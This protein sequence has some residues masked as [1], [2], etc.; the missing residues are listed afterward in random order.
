MTTQ[1][2]P[3]VPSPGA[4]PDLQDPQALEAAVAAVFGHIHREHMAD[5]PLSNKA[6]SVA[7]LGFQSWQGRTLEIGRAHV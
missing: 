4:P 7:T 6:L 1:P 3:G 5:L 2:V